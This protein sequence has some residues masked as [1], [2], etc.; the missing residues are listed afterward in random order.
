LSSGPAGASGSPARETPDGIVI[1]VR[2]TPKSGA[3]TVT[4]VEV[5]GGQTVVKARV[6]AAPED[7]KANAALARLIAEWM[8]EPKTNAEVVSGGKS[9]LKQ[10][11]VRGDSTLLMNRLLARLQALNSGD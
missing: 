5:R 1:A 7:G 2:L 6:R 3:D 11:L 10:V 4:G 8:N 9:R